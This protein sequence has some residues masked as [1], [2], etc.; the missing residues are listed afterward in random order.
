MS[1]DKE[2]KPT[3]HEAIADGKA[4]ETDPIPPQADK[5]T[6]L[7][8][9]E[10]TKSELSTGRTFARGVI[11]AWDLEDQKENMF[12]ESDAWFTPRPELALHIFE[13]TTEGGS[14]GYKALMYRVKGNG[15]VDGRMEV[16]LSVDMLGDRRLGTCPHTKQ[17]VEQV[18]SRDGNMVGWVCNHEQ[19]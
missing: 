1:K 9:A 18:Y 15:K 5:V 2:Q 14:N 17:Q 3:N 7:D 6:D 12:H 4:K 13:E 19:A 8:P 11:Q 10:F 16:P